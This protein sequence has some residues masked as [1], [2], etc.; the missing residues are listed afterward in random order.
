MLSCDDCGV[1]FRREDNLRRHKNHHCK[2]S[3]K[4]TDE[5]PCGAK[6]RWISAVSTVNED[7]ES[8]TFRV[9]M[10]INFAVTNQNLVRP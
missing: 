9:L 1:S 10:E 4:L 3:E 2:S 7:P 6:R 8:T 5:E